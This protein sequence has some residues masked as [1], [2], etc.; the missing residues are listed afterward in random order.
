[1]TRRRTS[2]S[3]VTLMELLIAVS[4]VSFISLVMV[5]AMRVG[6]S[7]M[8]KTNNKF[9]ANRKVTAVEK[10]MLSQIAG[11]MPLVTECRPGGGPPGGRF[12]MFEG[13]PDTLRFVSN[14]SL[15]EAARGYARLLE[16][17]VIPGEHGVG[18]R[19]VVNERIYGGPFMVGALCAGLAPNEQG[20]LM[21]A[22]PPVEVGPASFV[23]ADKLAYCRFSYRQTLPPPEME[24]WF[25]AWSM[26]QLLP[27]GIRIEIAP[28]APD[29]GRLQL[30]SIT[31]PVHVT[32]WLMGPYA[33]E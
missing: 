17:Q 25:P 5:M 31:A 16:F 32:R 11:L 28:L 13:K 26:P 20:L 15:A 23:L 18:V 14:Y 7:A 19:L 3:G 24:R 1:M 30:L 10:V 12:S 29:P 4:L 2:Q 22:F 21:P 9:I 33:D 6:L 27:S 8:E